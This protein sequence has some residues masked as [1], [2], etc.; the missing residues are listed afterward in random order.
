MHLCYTMSVFENFDPLVFGE[1]KLNN[2][3]EAT[4]YRARIQFSAVYEF[5]I[6]GRTMT[7]D[8]PIGDHSPWYYTTT[9]RKGNI[10]KARTGVLLQGFYEF[11]DGT[12]HGRVGYKGLDEADGTRYKADQGENWCSE[13]YSCVIKHNFKGIM[14]RST[15]DYVKS[16]FNN[17][18]AGEEAPSDSTIKND[19]RRGDYLAIDSTNDGEVNHSAM[20]LAYDRHQKE[21]YTLDGNISGRNMGESRKAGNEVYITSRPLS[22][23]YYWGQLTKDMVRDED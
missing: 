6:G 15:V 17:R 14:S 18:D 13:F 21:V 19:I 23:V 7:Y 9:E 1:V 11:Y 22:R 4:I 20:F 12:R 2:L 3:S 5:S 16:F 10:G 8:F